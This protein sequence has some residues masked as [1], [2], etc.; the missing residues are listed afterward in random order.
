[1]SETLATDATAPAE[2]KDF[3]RQIVREDLASGK[4]TVIRTRFPP[5]PNGYLHIGHAKAICLDFG[6]AAEFGGLCN[7]RLDD[8]NP[9]KEDPEFVVAIQDDVRWLGFEWAQLRHA[10]DYFEVYYLAAEKLI[11]DGHAF[12]CDLSA[13][14]VR[15]YRG[16]LTEPGRN[17]PFRERSADENLGLFRRMRA[18]EFPDGARTLR[19]RIDMGS[20]NINLRDPALYRIKH[21]EHQNTGNAWPIYPMYD[22]AHSLGDAVEGITHS[23]CT[24]EFEDHRPLYDWCVDKVDLAAHPELLQPLLDKGLPREAAKPRQIEFSRLNINYTVMSKRKLTALVEEQLVDGWDDP[25]MYTLQGLRRRGYTPAAMRLFVDRVGISK[26]NSLID[27]SVLE[28]CLRED[29]DTA[30]ARRM[31]VI[32]PIKLVLSNLPE[33]HNE[34][35]NFS[36]HPK[37][38]SFGTR[39]VPFSRELWI[40]REDFAELPPKGWKRLVPGGEVRLRGAGIARVDEMIKDAAGEIVELRGWL[41]PESRP[42]MEGANRKIKGTIHWVSAAH[43]V[44]A[45]IRLYDRLFSVEKP[46]DESEGKTY[47]NYLNPESKRSVRGY[48]EPSAAQAAPEQSFQF[49]RTGYFVADRR[50]HSA[51]TPVF[52]RSVTLRDTWAK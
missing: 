52:N 23:L 48:V 21:V 13:E 26:Q 14:Q 51:A 19:A 38:E 47:R 41:D 18:G 15:E 1:M 28:G 39:E 16:T 10:S 49:E 11:R 8:T 6:L 43:A 17:S 22:F 25:R 32:D 9:A 40:E 46:D 7:L 2:K 4:H 5:E 36:N 45:E 34:T 31:A 29:L 3:I 24:L 42:G 30:A 37:D 20:G 27:F 35:L 44:E 33:G 12:V 50:D